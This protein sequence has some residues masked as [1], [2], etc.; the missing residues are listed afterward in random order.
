VYVL[1]HDGGHD[2]LKK[3]Y[4]TINGEDDANDRLADL[5]LK[6]AETL[7]FMQTKKKK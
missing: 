3:L 2:E 7:R 1:K 5:T 6:Q 4:D